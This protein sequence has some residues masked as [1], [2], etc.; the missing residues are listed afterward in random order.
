MW[1]FSC[2]WFCVDFLQ[3]Q[4]LIRARVSP[5][6]GAGPVEEGS[7]PAGTWGRENGA[8]AE[9][10]RQLQEAEREGGKAAGGETGGGT[11][12]KE[13]EEEEDNPEEGEEENSPFKPFILPCK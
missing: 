6:E 7:G 1:C 5:E 12:L 10:E 3:R 9:G 4:R 2:S 8:P 11:Q 13:E